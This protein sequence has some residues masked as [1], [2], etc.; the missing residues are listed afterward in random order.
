MK[1]KEA[2]AKDETEEEYGIVKMITLQN[3]AEDKNEENIKRR[4]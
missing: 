2:D 1:R 4:S 3:D